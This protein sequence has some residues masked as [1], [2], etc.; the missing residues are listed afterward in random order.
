MGEKFSISDA[1]VR[2]FAQKHVENVQKRRKN[3]WNS[4]KKCSKCEFLNRNR[5]VLRSSTLALQGF[6]AFGLPFSIEQNPEVLH[7]S[8]LRSWFEGCQTESPP[9]IIGRRYG[10]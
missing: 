5:G 3:A 2:K 8:R 6:I 9:F 7:P 10:G 4:S 1:I